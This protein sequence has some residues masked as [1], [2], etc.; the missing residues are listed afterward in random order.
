MKADAVPTVQD[1]QRAGDHVSKLLLEYRLY[2]SR[3]FDML[4]SLQSHNRDMKVRCRQRAVTV[5]CSRIAVPCHGLGS[6][7]THARA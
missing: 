6:T 1:A 2:S 3:L 4:Q 7:H 5:L